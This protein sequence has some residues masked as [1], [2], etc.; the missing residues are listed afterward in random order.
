MLK[1]ISAM[2]PKGHVKLELYNDE[3]VFF[4]KEKKNLV[5]QSANKIV[6]EMMADPA[7]VLRV[8]QVDKG[9]AAL[10]ANSDLLYPFNLTVKAEAKTKFENNWGIANI[11]TDFDIEELKGITSLD[12]VKVGEATLVIN[13]DVFLIDAAKGKIKFAVAPT[14]AVVIEFHKVK[15][16]YM[17]MIAGTE[18]VKVNGETWNRGVTPNN[19]GKVYS[20]NYR[21]GEVYFQ[22]AQV[23]VEVTYD[24]HMN[25]SL[26][27]MALGGKPS[28]LHPNYQ[29]V[30]FGNSNKLDVDMSNE[31]PGSRMAI[32]YPSS[33]TEGATELEPAIPTQ[34]IATVAKTKADLTI[35]HNGDGAT[36]VLTY[37]LPNVHDSGSGAVGRTLFEVTAVR[38]TTTSTDILPANVTIVTNTL[39][40]V[41]VKFLDA[42]VAVGDIIKIDYRLKLDDRH[43]VYQLGQSPVVELK[44]VKHTDA[45]TGKITEYNIINAGLKPNEGD[46]WISNPNT[47]HITFASGNPVGKDPANKPPQVQTPGQLTIEYKVNSGTVVKFVADFPKGVPAPSV[48]EITKTVNIVTG[49]TSVTLDYPIAKDVTGLFLE[50]VVKVGATTL[51]SGQYT[52]SL[53]GKTITPN[54][55]SVGQVVSV[56]HKYE[57]TTH[58]I[59]QVAMFDDKIGGKMFNISGIGPVTKDKNTG[60]RVTW[61]VTF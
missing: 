51:A 42:D 25:Y 39:G 26:G 29:P 50:P 59:Y 14:E 56:K 41:E 3:G 27:F 22:T 60:M 6:A 40:L 1:D 30:E 9:D 16:P 57:K 17:K 49:Q 19:E 21:T 45:G 7:K 38:N 8:S 58:D 24:Y 54:S 20:V 33:I 12:E 31:L 61:S 43:L 36:K 46:V 48:E 13:Q 55:I 53:D 52:I 28:P 11:N 44:S 15:N 2:N 37:A 18:V 23:K 32:Q 10:S 4:I 34:A 35:N 5:V 47:G